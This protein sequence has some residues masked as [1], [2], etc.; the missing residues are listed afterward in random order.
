MGCEKDLENA[1]E[2]ILSKLPEEIHSEI[3]SHL[4]TKDAVRS[5]VLSRS[6]RHTWTSLAD[7]DLDLHGPVDDTLN[8]FVD[9]VN[10]ALT[11]RSFPLVKTFRLKIEGEYSSSSLKSWIEAAISYKIQE[12]DLCIRRAGFPEINISMP[13]L[14]ILRLESM[15]FP[16]DCMIERMLSSFINLEELILYRLIFTPKTAPIHIRS[17]SLKIL[18]IHL[19]YPFEMENIHLKFVVDAPKL[20]FVEL[21]SYG[22]L[23]AAIQANSHTTI[24]A[25]SHTIDIDC[26]RLY[27]EACLCDYLHF[28]LDTAIQ[29]CIVGFVTNICTT[30]KVLA[31][32]PNIFQYLFDEFNNNLP[33]FPKLNQLV[34]KYFQV[35]MP[36]LLDMLRSS[37]NL[38]VLVLSK[39][40]KDFFSSEYWDDEQNGVPQCLKSSIEKFE[41]NGYSG[42]SEDV[43]ILEYILKN[44]KALKKCY[45]VAF[46]SND[47]EEPFKEELLNKLSVL[48]KTC[49]VKIEHSKWSPLS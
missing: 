39:I 33:S 43:K 2:D 42:C 41:Y 7:L 16:V 11:F 22:G 35:G 28:K 37:P 19:N 14:K 21:D 27:L 1:Y 3:L 45:I 44:A 5:S 20:E 13:N 32:S 36:N 8:S 9:S 23:I 48:S 38:K 31:L 10:T 18:K 40:Y 17:S 15:R 30:V 24:Q 4:S 46:S 47:Y 29:S 6:W 25:N 49:Q 34:V 26:V 12:L